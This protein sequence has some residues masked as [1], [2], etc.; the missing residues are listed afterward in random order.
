[1]RKE[2][3]TTTTD[4]QSLTELTS[5]EIL[6]RWMDPPRACNIGTVDTIEVSI[7]HIVRPIVLG[8][9]G[10]VRQFPSLV[11]YLGRIGVEVERWQDFVLD[12]GPSAGEGLV[13]QPPKV[14]ENLHIGGGLVDYILIC[15][16]EVV[17]YDPVQV[18]LG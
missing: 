16:L 6:S 7:P 2:K 17:K 11:L 15:T 12:M 4:G 10:A 5:R 9:V 13:I 8:D 1:M 18:S 3:R 14:P